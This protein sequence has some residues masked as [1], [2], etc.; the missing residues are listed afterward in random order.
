MKETRRQEATDGLADPSIAPVP[1]TGTQD[2][3]LL[4]HVEKRLHCNIEALKVLR[5]LQATGRAATPPERDL[6][7]KWTSWGAMTPV[8]MPK[9]STVKG[10]IGRFDDQRAELRS[11]LTEQEWRRARTC[12]ADAY[13]TDT[14]YA[15][16]I[17]A[18]VTA[19]PVERVLEP[20][21]G[22]GTFIESAPGGIDVTGVEIDTITAEICRHLHPSALV[23]NEDFCRS[24][25]PRAS[26]DLVVGNVP[27]GK[28]LVGSP[29]RGTERHPLHDFFIIKALKLTRP[30]GVVAVITSRHTLDRPDT[31]SRSAMEVLGE[32]LGAV[33]LPTGAHFDTAGTDVVSDI[34]VLRR[35]H[36]GRRTASGPDWHDV[37]EIATASGDS[38]FINRYFEAFPEHVIG[39]VYSGFKDNGSP[40][41][42]VANP[43]GTPHIASRIREL[44]SQFSSESH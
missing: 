11:L 34:V 36:E 29:D 27:F 16:A 18:S 15:E 19:R 33:R 3:R 1:A 37:R 24:S 20:G 12:I 17:W 9:L 6:L 13:F 4:E 14:S 5:A 28:R 22:I 10:A 25:L 35:H 30:G 8:F 44:V 7:A 39:D 31:G 41:L 26:F 2:G 21:C 40:Y 23:L 32:F 42:G 38:L 43:L